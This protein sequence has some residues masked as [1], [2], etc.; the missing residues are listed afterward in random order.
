MKGE[1]PPRMMPVVVLYAATLELTSNALLR[2]T[3]EGLMS[4]AL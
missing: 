3:S 2:L 4:A 1:T